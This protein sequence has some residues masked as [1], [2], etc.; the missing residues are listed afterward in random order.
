[1][2]GSRTPLDLRPTESKPHLVDSLVRWGWSLPVR[3]RWSL[4]ARSPGK[5]GSSAPAETTEGDVV[6]QTAGKSIDGPRTSHQCSS[7]SQ[8]CTGWR[9]TTRL[10]HQGSDLSTP[11][12][13]NMRRVH[14]P[15]SLK[16]GEGK[17][18]PHPVADL[19]LL[20]GRSLLDNASSSRAEQFVGDDQGWH[21]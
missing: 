1:M 8:A 15:G 2:H 7:R 19:G 3:W 10:P 4:P 21:R 9:D 11:W 20:L 13:T 14:S 12:A 5:S 17:Y 16:I 18:S 6:V